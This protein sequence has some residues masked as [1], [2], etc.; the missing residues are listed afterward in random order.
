M[1][2]MKCR[3]ALV[4]S[5]TRVILSTTATLGEFCEKEPS[6]VITVNSVLL[7]CRRVTTV[8]TRLK[9]LLLKTGDVPELICMGTPF[10]TGRTPA[11]GCNVRF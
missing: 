11:K 10:P 7:E 9:T 8:V 2:K 6:E 5:C 3:S 4:S 1:R